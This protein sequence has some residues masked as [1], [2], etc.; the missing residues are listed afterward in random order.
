VRI[1]V[2]LSVCLYMWVPCLR[3][4]EESI[5]C[6]G[7]VVKITFVSTPTWVLGIKHQQAL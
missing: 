4:S 5:R 3:I 2:C 6:S 1:H 7:I